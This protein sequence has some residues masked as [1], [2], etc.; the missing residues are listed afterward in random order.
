MGLADALRRRGERGATPVP[1]RRLACRRLARR[2]AFKAA[3]VSALPVAGADLFVNG[4]LL[5][6][7]LGRINLAYG[8]GPE[9]IRQ[10]P[11]PTRT[12]LESLTRELGTYLVGRAVTQGLV[13]KVLATFG[14]RVGAQQ[15]MK[16][17]PVVG[18]AASG[19]M[20]GWLFMRVC[21]RHIEH[22]E[23]IAAQLPQ[24]QGATVHQDV[25]DI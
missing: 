18:L 13:I 21:E 24:L 4:Q 1:T 22:C 2:E 15:A 14:A 16:L 20:S 19:A 10:L 9:Q 3:G 17:A 25:I 8:L 23:L 5:A 7:T 6:S 11:A 12:R